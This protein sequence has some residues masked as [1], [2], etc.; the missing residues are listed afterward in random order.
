MY[1][2]NRSWQKRMSAASAVP[3]GAPNRRRRGERRSTSLCCPSVSLLSVG[4]GQLNGF[5]PSRVPTTTRRG[6][7]CA[8]PKSARSTAASP[9][10]IRA[11]LPGCRAGHA[12][13][14]AS[15]RPSRGA[16]TAHGAGR[17]C[18]RSTGARARTAVRGRSRTRAHAAEAPAPLARPRGTCCG[19]HPRREAARRPRT[20]D[21]ALPPI[22]KRGPRGQAPR[23]GARERRPAGSS[24]RVCSGAC[25][26]SASRR[27][28]RRRRRQVP[29]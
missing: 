14:F 4:S 1:F 7:F 8:R 20:V 3:R 18:S 13:A 9:R 29:V 5:S 12:D 16:G 11:P 25:S 28:G 19:R 26:P 24:T 22:P 21:I 10:G 2:G 15:S 23:I 27:S 17:G 6:R